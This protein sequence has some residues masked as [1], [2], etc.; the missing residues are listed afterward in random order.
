MLR[1]DFL[2]TIICFLGTA[3]YGQAA[4]E[5][6]KAIH[7]MVYINA[8]QGIDPSEATVHRVLRLYGLI[9]HMPVCS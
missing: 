5:K 4:G 1:I 2:L 7:K 3:A 8:E 9:I 6:S